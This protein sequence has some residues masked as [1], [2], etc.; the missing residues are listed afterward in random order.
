MGY[1]IYD[2]RKYNLGFYIARQNLRYCKHKLAFRDGRFVAVPLPQTERTSFNPKRDV[3]KVA[4]ALNGAFQLGTDEDRPFP[5]EEQLKP[6][7]KFTLTLVEKFSNGDRIPLLKV[8]KQVE[9]FI[10]NAIYWFALEDVADVVGEHSE[11]FLEFVADNVVEYTNEKFALKANAICSGKMA[12]GRFVYRKPFTKGDKVQLVRTEFDEITGVEDYWMDRA[13]TRV[14]EGKAMNGEQLLLPG[15]IYTVKRGGGH[16]VRLEEN[17]KYF[18]NAF[19][20][21]IVE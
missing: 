3:A 10:K 4:R 21:D 9:D 15:K 13:N 5:F 12:D 1:D 6:Y 14:Y 11:S 17:D 8:V 16:N 20:F 2:L 18:L 7:K 19:H